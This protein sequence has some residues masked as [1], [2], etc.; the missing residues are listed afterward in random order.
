[1]YLIP[2]NIPS[3]ILKFLYHSMAIDRILFNLYHRY[4][5]YFSMWKQETESP[6]RLSTPS[7]SACGPQTSSISKIWDVVRNANSQAIFLTKWV[8]PRNLC[9]S[10]PSDDS[11]TC[12]N[13]RTTNLYQSLPIQINSTDTSCTSRGGSRTFGPEEILVEKF[14]H[15]HRT[16][17]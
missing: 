11:G 8:Q 16:L 3:K 6:S 14:D 17:R 5:T 7:L 2:K 1:M 9:F 10:K 13:L 15:E 12:S 4:S